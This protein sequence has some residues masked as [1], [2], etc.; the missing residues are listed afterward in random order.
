[1]G[2][3]VRIYPAALTKEEHDARHQYTAVL[4][5]IPRN[6]HPTD[7]MRIKSAS[8]AMA[9]GI[10]KFMNDTNKPWIYLNFQSKEDLHNAMDVLPI[11]NGRQLVWDLLFNVRNFCP[12]CSSPAHKAKDCDD[13]RS[14][15]RKPT[16]KALI[17]TYKRFGIV[18]AATK[19]ADKQTQAQQQRNTRERSRSKSR[20]QP[21]VNF[22]KQGEPSSYANA[23]KNVHQQASNLE[24]SIH[25]PKNKGKD[26]VRHQQS[27][28][29][30]PNLNSGSF[31]EIQKY[32]QFMKNELDVLTNQMNGWKQAY[33]RLDSRLN[34][35]EQHLNITPPPQPISRSATTSSPKRTSPASNLVPARPT[36]TTSFH[37]QT[38]PASTLA[39]TNNNTASTQ[40]TV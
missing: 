9:L 24:S 18:N 17:N 10:P 21:R 26:P 11:L 4:R 13:I 16:P 8:G 5:N 31:I 37:P 1:M 32:M 29:Q 28:P 36:T 35:V 30:Q 19:R 23:L 3:C 22:Q 40:H 34:T 12:R 38:K 14:R 7:F 33:D 20:S 15:G 2:E 27:N 25:A 6:F 39:A